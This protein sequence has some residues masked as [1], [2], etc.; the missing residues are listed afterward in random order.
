MKAK[1]IA[2]YEEFGGMIRLI[3]LGRAQITFIPIEEAEYY[4]DK[5]GYARNDFNIIR[6]ADMPPGEKRYIMCS[7]SI[8]NEVMERLDA[9]IK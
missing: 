6:F 1:R 3:K 8:E 5:M 7:K 2:T 4:I 9:A